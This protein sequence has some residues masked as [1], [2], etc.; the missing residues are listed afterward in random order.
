MKRRD[1]HFFSYFGAQEALRT[2]LNHP[3]PVCMSPGNRVPG[4]N[5]TDSGIRHEG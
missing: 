1:L 3:G 4:P 5:E 2:D